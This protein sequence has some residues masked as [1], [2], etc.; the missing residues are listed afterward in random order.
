VVQHLPSKGEALSSSPTTVEREGERE[1][2]RDRKGD[3]ERERRWS[4]ESRNE[5]SLE[6]LEKAK[7]RSFPYGLQKDEPFHYFDFSS[8]LLNSWLPELYEIIL[9]CLKSPVLW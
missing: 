2:E 7:N 6:K 1:R 8:V 4:H 5:G 3:R 9:R